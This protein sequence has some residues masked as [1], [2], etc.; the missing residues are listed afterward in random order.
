MNAKT[1]ARGAEMTMRDSTGLTGPQSTVQAAR[2]PTASRTVPVWMRSQRTGCSSSWLAHSVQ[3][4][5]VSYTCSVS[6]GSSRRLQ[7][8]QQSAERRDWRL[9]S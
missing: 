9:W 7:L 5:R 2:G 6:P 4:E 8:A 1:S 3:S